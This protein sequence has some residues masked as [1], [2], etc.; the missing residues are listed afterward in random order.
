MISL[1]CVS[2][3]VPLEATHLNGIQGSKWQAGQIHLISYDL[4]LDFSYNSEVQPLHNIPGV[5]DTTV[6]DSALLSKLSH[7]IQYIKT[8]IRVWQGMLSV[9]IFLSYSYET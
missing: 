2:L 3:E 5:Q 1:E 4:D 7:E 8:V 9:M 6:L